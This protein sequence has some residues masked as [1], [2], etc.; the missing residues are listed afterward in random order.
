MTGSM[1]EFGASRRTKAAVPGVRW[2]ML[3]LLFTAVGAIWALVVP[4]GGSADEPD[5]LIKA[6]AVVRG[7]PG[8]PQEQVASYPT[9]G[10]QTIVEVPAAYAGIKTAAECFRKHPDVPAGSC[11]EPIARELGPITTAVTASGQYNPVYYAMVGLPTFLPWP[12][13]GMR[14]TRLL[15]A[16]WGAAFLTWAV[17]GVSRFRS[18]LA[19]RWGVLVACTP[20]AMFLTG[21]VNPNGLEIACA[22]SLWAA[23]IALA[24]LP[25]R[26]G[27]AVPADAGAL[28]VQV[29]V[30]A[31]VLC[32]MRPISPLWAA[33]IVL[34]GVLLAGW[35]RTR[36]LLRLPAMAAAAGL[37]VLTTAWVLG[38]TFTRGPLVGVTGLAPHL[39]DPVVGTRLLLSNVGV[40]LAEAI[41]EFG[42]RDTPAGAVTYAAWGLTC[43]GLVLLAVVRAPGGRWRPLLVLTAALVVVVPV[44]VS[45]P[46]LADVN[47]VWQG[48]YN[49]PLMA[50]VPLLAGLG[51]ALEGGVDGAR[52]GDD[53]GGVDGAG[54]PPPRRGYP[55]VAARRGRRV[56]RVGARRGAAPRRAAALGGRGRRPL[57]P[58]PPAR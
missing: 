41:G 46:T 11:Q 7:Q 42:W 36:A 48:R 20:T 39:A 44:A 49:L 18:A 26:D 27:C 52:A 9:K 8:G 1:H 50:G 45:L 34:V 54:A 2:P 6:A 51:L 19:L 43:A 53:A 40:Q 12:E 56:D 33:L 10:P 15:S 31:A 38:W 17:H 57:R 16:A 25:R 23:M 21:A 47:Y 3:W 5:H 29:A 22:V 24:A 58:A 13:L 32:T 28:L 37:G 4:I 55:A 30:S 35:D 14:L